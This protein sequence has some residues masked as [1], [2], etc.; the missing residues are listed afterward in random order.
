MST[1]PQFPPVEQGAPGPLDPIPGED[2][3]VD[4]AS[5]KTRRPRTQCTSPG[6]RLCGRH[7]SS[8]YSS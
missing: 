3:A 2:P 4:A 7:S 8:A 6:P 1:D 5:I